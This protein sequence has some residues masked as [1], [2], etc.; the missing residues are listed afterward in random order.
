MAHDIKITAYKGLDPEDN[1]PTFLVTLSSDEF[2]D[3]IDCFAGDY[4]DDAEKALG[5]PDACVLALQLGIWRTGRA[6]PIALKFLEDPRTEQLWQRTSPAEA[7][8]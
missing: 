5:N 3:K 4:N 8:Q 6:Q 1:T 7:R 2:P